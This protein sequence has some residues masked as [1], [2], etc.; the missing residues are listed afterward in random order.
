[1]WIDQQSIENA[2]FSKNKPRIMEAGL[3]SL[4]NLFK[5]GG[6]DCWLPSLDFFG[7]THG[8]LTRIPSV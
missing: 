1:M 7:F 8:S 3:Y 4:S 2:M 6:I 5:K